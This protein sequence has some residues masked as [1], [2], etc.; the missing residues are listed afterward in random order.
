[1]YCVF[2][3]NEW[4]FSIIQTNY[5][6]NRLQSMDDGAV[7]FLK[8]REMRSAFYKPCQIVLFV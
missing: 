7:S 8:V 2:W 4:N 1:M 3:E 5:G 6:K